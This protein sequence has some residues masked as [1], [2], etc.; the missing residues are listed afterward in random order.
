MNLERL[1]SDEAQRL[2][3][4]PILHVK[5]TALPGCVDLSPHL[6]DAGGVRKA[7]A[8]DLRASGSIENDAVQDHVRCGFGCMSVDNSAAPSARRRW[9]QT[10]MS[11]ITSRVKSRWRRSPLRKSIRATLPARFCRRPLE[12]SSATRI[13]RRSTQADRPN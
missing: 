2:E 3:G 6:V 11:R 4:R 10:C 1:A 5:Y 13:S 9:K 12:G 7:Y 8:F